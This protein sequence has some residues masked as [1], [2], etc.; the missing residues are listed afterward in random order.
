MK[1]QRLLGS[2]EDDDDENDDEAVDND[3]CITVYT[4]RTIKR[5]AL[6]GQ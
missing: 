4:A 6:H 2:Y 1:I 5:G 3:I